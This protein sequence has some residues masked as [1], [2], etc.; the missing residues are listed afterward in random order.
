[1]SPWLWTVCV[2]SCIAFSAYCKWRVFACLVI[3]SCLLNGN[4]ARKRHT[5]FISQTVLWTALDAHSAVPL[6]ASWDVPIA[7]ST[8][9]LAELS[10]I[11][12]AR[13]SYFAVPSA[14][15]WRSCS[16]V[17]LPLKTQHQSEHL[18]SSARTGWCARAVWYAH[19]RSWWCCH[20][21]QTRR[22]WSP[23][24][25]S[26]N[27]QWEWAAW[28]VCTTCLVHTLYILTVLSSDPVIKVRFATLYENEGISILSTT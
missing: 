15:P 20:M 3:N 8:F 18:E 4:V 10:A 13:S 6:A 17:T 16:L 19:P 28:K 23:L 14:L 1:M 2:R 22:S 12:V 11:L 25:F 5:C 9:P 21:T 7:L 27:L 26:L 24:S